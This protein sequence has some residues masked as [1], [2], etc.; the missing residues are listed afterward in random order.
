MKLL[1][2]SLVLA[3]LASTASAGNSDRYNDMRLDT[4]RPAQNA[5]TARP[6]TT[7]PAVTR[8]AS[9]DRRLP[10]NAVRSPDNPTPFYAYDSPFGVG[11]NNDSR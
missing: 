5:E 2:T 7:G 11:P 6:E 1:I 10:R 4:S 9:P 8:R 3:L